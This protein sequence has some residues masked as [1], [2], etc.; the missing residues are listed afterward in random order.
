MSYTYIPDYNKH[1][2]KI[3]DWFLKH[4]ELLQGLWC[5]HKMKKIFIENF[6]F[7]FAT[8]FYVKKI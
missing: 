5:L 4:K 8:I 6:N 3:Q 1:Y 7:T 2:T